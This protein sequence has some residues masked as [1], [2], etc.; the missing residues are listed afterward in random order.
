MGLLD[1]NTFLTTDENGMIDD[2]HC[3]SG[4]TRENVGH[5][6]A[7]NGE[8]LIN[9]T[10]DP[11][12]IVVG[13]TLDPGSIVVRQASGHIVTRS[14]Q[15]IHTCIIPDKEGAQTY[16]HVGIFQHGFDSK[17]HY[18][19]EVS[20]TISSLNSLTASI[21]AS[22][23]DK[24]SDYGSLFTLKCVSSDSP[25]TTVHW[26]KNGQLLAQSNTYQMTQILQSGATS[27]Y[28]NLLT[29]NSGPYA[30]IGDYSCEVSNSLGAAAINI[31]VEGWLYIFI[32]ITIVHLL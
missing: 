12:D 20:I 17:S 25:A 19:S 1:N 3:T 10:I 4:S 22:S 6:I 14:F 16:I 24:T 11:F 8:D 32:V 7:P 2:I 13:D 26:K 23:L 29:I 27:T 30:V 28:F 18:N 5:W 21:V 31:S 15:G 9:S